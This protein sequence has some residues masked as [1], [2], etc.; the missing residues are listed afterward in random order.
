MFQSSYKNCGDSVQISSSDQS[1]RKKIN[2]SDPNLLALRSSLRPLFAAGGRFSWSC[3]ATEASVEGRV[4][5][6]INLTVVGATERNLMKNNKGLHK[7]VDKQENIVKEQYIPW[8][9]LFCCLEERVF[10]ATIVVQRKVIN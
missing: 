1:I 2:K 9:A 4:G 3:A 5:N 6:F 7:M 10:V 8:A